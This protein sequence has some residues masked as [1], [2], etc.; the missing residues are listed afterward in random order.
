MKIN[1]AKKILIFFSSIF[2]LFFLGEMGVRIMDTLRGHNFFSNM[3]RDKFEINIRSANP[4]PFR[5]FGPNFYEEKDG[6][7]YISSSHHELYPLIKPDNT[8]RIVCFG[9]STTRNQWT[10]EKYKLHYP[11]VLQEMLQQK[12]PGKKIEVINVGYD[13]YSTPH[14]LILLELDVISWSPDL[15][16]ISENNNDMS[17]SYWTHFSFDYSNKYKLK[18]YNIPDYTKDFT[19]IN[20]LFRWSSFYWFV[21]EKIDKISA[22][23]VNQ[24]IEMTKIENAKMII[25]LEPP[26]ISRYIFKRNLLT[27]YYIA[28]NWKI[29]VLFASQPLKPNVQMSDYMPNKIDEKVF[30]NV[31]NKEKISHHKCFNNIIKEVAAETNSYFIDHD[32]LLE[33]NEKYFI[34]AVHYSK[35]GVEKLARNYYEYIVNY[36]IIHEK[37]V[38]YVQTYSNF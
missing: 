2:V 12:Y 27:F 4:I 21:K 35:I 15:V 5:T 26:K 23:S 17:A 9:G 34:D 32:S 11:G 6:V 33:G 25:G 37:S 3:H 22:G 29:P 31:S 19:T 30:L 14:F 28:A 7:K 13:A 24:N 36:K 38:D 16:I 18:K 8:F 1:T 10:Y 20:A